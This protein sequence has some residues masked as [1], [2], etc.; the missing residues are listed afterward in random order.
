MKL[1]KSIY[2]ILSLAVLL[3][4][5][6]VATISG[7][8]VPGKDEN[9]PFLV[10]FGK[11]GKTSWGDDDFNQIFFLTIL[12]DFKQPFYIRVFEPD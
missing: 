7:Q 5:P 10:N 3:G 12:K 9:I 4:L 2:K 6:T 1:N 11:D 8:A